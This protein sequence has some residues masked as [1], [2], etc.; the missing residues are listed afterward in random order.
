MTRTR[1]PS[2][3]FLHSVRS[4]SRLYYNGTLFFVSREEAPV[5]G[6]I[7]VSSPREII[8]IRCLGRSQLLR[9]FVE[10]SYNNYLWIKLRLKF[11]KQRAGHAESGELLDINIRGILGLTLYS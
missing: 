7:K 11:Q 1:K 9:N 6:N 8:T 5:I 2:D 4:T 10:E 3:I